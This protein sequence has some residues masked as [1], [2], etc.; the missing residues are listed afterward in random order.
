M[1]PQEDKMKITVHSYLTYI[2]K[3]INIIIFHYSNI[4]ASKINIRF[5]KEKYFH[6][7]GAKF[8]LLCE[9][10]SRTGKILKCSTSGQGKATGRYRSCHRRMKDR[11]K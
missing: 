2:F 11:E 5:F 7:F 3:T 10:T 9:S 8:L 1:D 4:T 6:S